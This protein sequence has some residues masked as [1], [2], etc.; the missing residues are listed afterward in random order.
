IYLC[1]NHSPN[2]LDIIAKASNKNV[3]SDALMKSSPPRERANAIRAVAGP[4]EQRKT[5]I[6]AGSVVIDFK[7]MRETSSKTINGTTDQHQ[8]EKPN[9]QSENAI[10]S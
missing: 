7:L 4:G 10:N 6:T 1:P 5:R 9:L 8:P 2:D 3:P